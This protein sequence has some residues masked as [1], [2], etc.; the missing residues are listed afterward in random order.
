M[1][2]MSKRRWTYVI[3]AIVAAVIVIIAVILMQQPIPTSTTP[4]VHTPPTVTTAAATGVGQTTATLNGNL[5]NLGTAAMV[6][7]G[8]RYGT[9]PS[10]QGAT[11]LSTASVTATGAFHEDLTGLTPATTYYFAAWA[12]GEGFAQAS[13]LSFTTQTQPTPQTRAPTVATNAA[14]PIGNTTATLNGNLG[15]LGTAS[16]VIVGFVY[17]T[18][19][20]LHGASNV[21]GGTESAAGLFSVP[22]AGLQSNTTYYVQAWAVGNGFATGSVLSFNTTA[23][24]GGNGH[25]VPPGWSHARC[26]DVPAHAKAYGMRA[27]CEFNMTYGEMKKQGLTFPPT[28]PATVDSLPSR[29]ANAQTRT[30]DPGNSS[31]H[32]SDR[33]RTW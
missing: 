3:T 26:P 5:G 19:Q 14:S 16:T 22:V 10:L 27:R 11:N 17:G 4:T 7:L 21:S 9:S 24:S 6:S 25:Q 31:D 28:T 15:N 30:A 20:D 23:L 13:A 18:S 32:R 8:F 29:Q 33:A 2:G 1:A 12:G